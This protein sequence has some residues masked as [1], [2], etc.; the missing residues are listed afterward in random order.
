MV[1]A[2]IGRREV[3]RERAVGV[4][5]WF[6]GSAPARASAAY[7]ASHGGSIAPMRRFCDG[8]TG[9]FPWRRTCRK[10]VCRRDALV[11]APT[12]SPQTGW[13][14]SHPFVF[15]SRRSSVAPFCL[16]E[17]PDERL[18]WDGSRR[19]TR[20]PARVRAGS[21]AALADVFKECN[22]DRCRQC[23][24]PYSGVWIGLRFASV[25]AAVGTKVRDAALGTKGRPRPRSCCCKNTA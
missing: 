18:R 15:G 9:R 12:V 19:G 6:A 5:L 11:C 1:G 3:G 25:G 13:W 14:C 16:R 24:S 22:G 2:R 17:A 20:D 8:D 7:E 10:L 21:G 4:P 23:N